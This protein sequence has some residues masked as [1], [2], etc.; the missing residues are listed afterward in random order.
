MKKMFVLLLTLLISA[1]CIHALADISTEATYESGDFGYNLLKDGTAEIARYYGGDGEL[2]IPSTLDGIPVTTIGYSAF[3]DT[4]V[5]QVTIPTS[6]TTIEDRAF[7]Y[8]FYLTRVIIP[9]SV[10]IIGSGAFRESSNLTSI[11]VGRDS[12]AR[13]FCIEHNLPYT[14]TNDVTAK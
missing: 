11:V 3:T 8:C 10:T 14:C 7:A 6:V 5:G 12:Y 13:Q 2:V 1:T 4:Y 9:D